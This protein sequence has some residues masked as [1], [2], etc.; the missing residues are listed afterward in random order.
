MTSRLSPGPLRIVFFFFFWFVCFHL[1]LPF[2]PSLT[3]AFVLQGF[4]AA[5]S[6]VVPF[7]RSLE[8]GTPDKEP[9]TPALGPVMLPGPQHSRLHAWLLPVASGKGVLNPGKLL[10]RC[11]PYNIHINKSH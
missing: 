8:G 9:S 4:P 1:F 3:D 7:C 6:E 11:R 10:A 2:S 5:L